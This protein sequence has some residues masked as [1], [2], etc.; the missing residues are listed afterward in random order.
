VDR[1]KTI[2]FID[3]SN[4]FHGQ[5]G[6]GWKIDWQKFLG[7]MEK[8]G[9]VWQTYFFASED[10]PPRA[11]QTAFYQ[12]LRNRL[13]WEVILFKLGQ[14]TVSC[15]KCGNSEVVPTEKGVDIGLATKM[16]ILGTNRAYETA[17]LVAGD[18]DYL[19]TVRFIKNLG[20]RIEIVSWRN[21]LS[22]DLRSESSAPVVYLDDLRQQIERV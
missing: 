20:L 2:C 15:K 17:L 19:E 1:G 21:A 22:G 6:A 3:N 4:V 18:K 12:L 5:Q 14:K 8:A 9:P 13:R 11:L 16:M 7:E 10:D